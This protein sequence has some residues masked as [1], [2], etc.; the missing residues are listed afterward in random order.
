MSIKDVEKINS[1]QMEI[2]SKKNSRELARIS[3]GHEK[4]KSEIKSANADE[5]VDIRHENLRYIA[6]ENEKKEKILE[7]MR[8][9]LDQT[10]KMT[11]GQIK[12]LKEN[13]HRVQKTESEKASA[14]RDKVKAENEL[15]LEDLGYRLAKEQKTIVN[16][17]QTQLNSINDMKGKEISTTQ[18][19]YQSTLNKQKND[20]TQRFQTDES[21][22]KKIKENQDGQFK[23]ERMS[24]H[25]RQ[26]QEKEKLVTSHNKI[27]ENRDTTYRKGIKEQ[28][29][30]FEKKYAESLKIRNDDLKRLD[31]LNAKVLS[32]MKGDLSTTLEKSVKRSD[33]PFY[34]FTELKPRLKEFEDRVEIMVDVPEH[35]KT[36]VQL[37]LHGKE[38]IINFNRRYDDA[39]KEPGKNHTLHKVESFTTRLLTNHHLD[40]KSVKQSYEAGVMTYVVKRA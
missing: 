5:L 10:A 33:D 27:L 25:L 16:D 36:D 30:F 6:G 8:T 11:E 18:G 19:H 35:A 2:L 4:L 15:Y 3:E 39:R 28:D 17:H 21:N 29:L 32:K 7:Q 34:Q 37:T 20:F 24:T 9:Q 22:N 38:A 13:T 31:N 14:A 12:D 26:E 40:A 23:K 1:R